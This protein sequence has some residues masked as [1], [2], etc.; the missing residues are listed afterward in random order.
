MV[1]RFCIDSAA[2]QNTQV[3]NQNADL[4]AFSHFA[5]P[6]DGIQ[7]IIKEMRVDLR[8]QGFQFCLLKNQ[9][10]FIIDCDQAVDFLSH[11]N[12]IFAEA[13]DFI[14]PRFF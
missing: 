3:F 5:A 10:V 11:H 4:R 9:F 8:L 14:I 12:E 13:S 1:D 7:N 2:Q 6:V